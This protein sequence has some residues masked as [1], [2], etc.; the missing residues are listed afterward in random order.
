[1]PSQTAHAPPVQQWFW[2]RL[3]SAAPGAIRAT[4]YVVATVMKLQPYM[5]MAVMHGYVWPGPRET[6]LASLVGECYS[7]YGQCCFVLRKLIIVAQRNEAKPD[8]HEEEEFPQAHT[9]GYIQLIVG[10][11]KGRNRLQ[12]LLLYIGSCLESW[13]LWCVV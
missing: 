2:C 4:L 5:A 1:M 11:W 3:C 10:H 8:S 7:I 13:F 9:F 12:V 6:F